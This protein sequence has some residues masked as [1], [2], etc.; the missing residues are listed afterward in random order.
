MRYAIILFLVAV[1]VSAVPS[2]AQAPAAADWHELVDHMVGPWRMTGDV[3]G[4]AAHHHVVA[5]W[6]L[7]KQFLRIEEKTAGDAPSDE[8][9]Y[10]SIWFLGYDTVSDRYVMHLMDTFGGRFS[11]TLGYG[12]RDGNT[13]RFVF[14][15]PDGP[16]HT[17]F[18]WDAQKQQWSW[19]MQQKDKDGH[20]TPFARLT[21]ARTP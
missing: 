11:E 8:R 12:T 9:R 20:W 5:G 16:F 2:R 19:L 14:E 17:D 7:D 10:D 4:R 13:I 15:Y 18:T 1:F 3:L 21:L 6:V